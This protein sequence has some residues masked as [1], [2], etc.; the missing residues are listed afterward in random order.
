ML[1][2]IAKLA[3][4][5]LLAGIAFVALSA[6]LMLV[7]KVLAFALVVGLA[8]KLF[9]RSRM[10]HILQHGMHYEQT[11]HWKRNFYTG[12]E[13]YVFVGKDRRNP[14]EN[15]HTSYQREHIIEVD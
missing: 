3:G 10:F 5:G 13:S 7:A 14:F 8:V 6:L 4:F 15:P 2:P 1:R 11:N 9:R 12:Q